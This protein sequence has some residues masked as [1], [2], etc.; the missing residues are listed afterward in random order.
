MPLPPVNLISFDEALA[1]E[2][3]YRKRHLLLGNGFS[4]AWK[5]D[6]FSY[7]ALLEQAN[8]GQ[9]SDVARH[10]FDIL[11]TTD[12]E[13][14]M[15]SLRSAAKLIAIY[16]LDQAELQDRLMRD[17][18][19]LREVL[20]QAIA[21]RHP[22]RPNAVTNK[23]YKHAKTFLSYFK[24]IYTVN[25]DL[26]LYWTLMQDEIDPRLGLDDGFRRPIE[27]DQDYVTWEIERTNSQDIFYLHG[28]LHIFDAGHEIQKYTWINTGIPLMDQIRT[29]LE[30]NLYPLFVSEGTS[31]QK[32]E[33]IK[34][35]D[36]LSRGRRS[37][38]NL[39][40]SLYIYGHSMAPNDEHII[41]LIETNKCE[42]LFVSLYGNPDSD[43]NKVIRKRCHDLVNTR[44]LQGN[45]HPLGLKF[46]DAASAKVWRD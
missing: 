45:Y 14:V 46:F 34:H 40:N 1:T 30:N 19:G 33:K 29:A 24:G 15:E 36:L 23:E 28:A 22:D 38:A 9:L 7:D 5:D 26:L 16:G 43:S 25:Y 18:I 17:A 31:K 8:F 12:F 37:F 41:R 42:W 27:G 20:V 4:R 2:P 13:V 11:G 44:K 10:A 21:G 32:L 35:S 3:N 39:G 6:I